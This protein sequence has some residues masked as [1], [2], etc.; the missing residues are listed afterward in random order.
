MVSISRLV[1]SLALIQLLTLFFVPLCGFSAEAQAGG[2][3]R[4]KRL[5]AS[6][7]QRQEMNASS[8]FQGLPWRSVGPVNQGGRLVDIEVVRNEPFTFYVGFASGGVWR[9]KNNGLTLEPIFD[10]QPCMIIGDIALDPSDPKV[11]WVGTG[12]NNS[13]RSSYG[14]LGVFRSGDGGDT[15]QHMGLTETDRI[16]RIVVDPR[17]S[18]RVYVASLGKLYTEGGE[19]GVHRTLDG[20]KTWDLILA[21]DKRTGFVDLLQ[22]PKNPDILYAASWERLRRPWMFDESGDGSGIW[23][24]RDGGETW[25]RLTGGFPRGENAGRIGLALCD[26]K[27][28]TIYAML[29][30]QRILPEEEWDLGASAVTPKRLRGMTKEEFLDQDLDD[31]EAF[32]NANDIDSELDARRVV[33]R[34]KSGELTVQDL[35]DACMDA[36][37]SLFE[38]DIRGVE[39]WRSD[40]GGETWRC[41]HDE[42]LRDLA[43]TYGYYFGQIRV[44]PKDP[45]RIYLLGVPFITSGDGGKTFAGRNSPKVHVD[46]QSLWINPDHP[47]NL[48]IGNDG[49]LYMSYDTGKTW[50]KLNSVSVGQF[51]AVCVDGKKPYNILGGLQDNGSL[52][53]PSTW[54]EGD[55]SWERIGGGDGM[56]C[57]VDPRD[58]ATLYTGYQFGHYS[59]TDPGGKRTTVRPRAKIKEPVFRFNW[60]TPIQLSPHVPDILYLGANRV[61]RSFDQG[62]TFQPISPDLT[63]SKERGNVPFGTLTTLCESTMTFGLIWA[64]TDDGNVHVTKD[65]GATWRDAGAGLPSN[66]WVTRVEPS[67]HEEKVCYVSF[68]GYRDDD[69]ASYLYRTAD[70]GTSWKSIGKG[71]PDEA[72]NVVREDPL[73][74]KRLYVGTDRGAYLSRDRGETWISLC[75]GLPNVPVHDLAV[76]HREREL[77]AGTHGRSIWVLDLLP[78]Q[79]LTKEIEEKAVHL[80]PVEDIKASRRWQRR[81]RPW[82]DRP[83]R[84]TKET[85][86]YWMKEGG[87]GKIRIQDED[88]RDLFEDTVS[89]TRGLNVYRW[90]YRLDPALALTAEKARLDEKAKELEEKEKDK[91]KLDPDEKKVDALQ[92]GPVEKGKGLGHMTY[93]SRGEYRI[94]LEFGGDSHEVSFKVKAPRALPSRVEE[95]EEIRGRK[96][97][98]KENKKDERNS[99]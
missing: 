45:D 29:D 94:R 93:V 22:D 90:N 39:V 49:G 48:I 12:E 23:R 15:F 59:R 32:L 82:W 8:P 96:K 89:A 60:C 66:R 91:D 44:S 7:K 87:K 20:G 70:L 27:P 26:S 74:P 95:E 75:G 53:G 18:N 72:V 56:Y 9:T 79:D 17:D 55:P 33:S 11:L 38:S 4:G 24:T 63:T 21:G 99:G 86:T 50:I 41:P 10:D 54:K 36:N 92:M 78:I 61:L 76:H 73:D 19:R 25:V 77:I 37:N 43:F 84:E 52:R 88:G 58:D 35:V 13:S 47:E 31:I 83:E 65:G 34:I 57:Q 98:K 3:D 42:S 69:I 85:I 62:E 1:R 30:N 71:L 80:F 5:L 67:L 64:G 68:S 46:H 51:Y 16:G 81:A 97:G 40:D 14:G 6:W 28:E 2:G